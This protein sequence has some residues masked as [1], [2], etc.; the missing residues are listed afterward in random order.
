VS[1]F[2]QSFRNLPVRVREEEE[3]EEG[4]EGEEDGEEGEGA[5]RGGGRGRPLASA[6]GAVPLTGTEA[7][8]VPQATPGAPGLALQALTTDGVSLLQV[9]VGLI[10]MIDF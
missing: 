6:A 9:R 1:S 3:E 2:H 4:E 8:G 10:E 7:A 5:V